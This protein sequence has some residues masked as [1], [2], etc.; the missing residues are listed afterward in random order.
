[1][2]EDDASPA[3]RLDGPRPEPT[4]APAPHDAESARDRAY[5]A[6][7]ERAHEVADE[8]LFAAPPAAPRQPLAPA[9]PY[10]LAS[11]AE[12]EPPRAGGRARA[13]SLLS[14]LVWVTTA[15]AL[16]VAVAPAALRELGLLES[17]R[18]RAAH[19]RLPSAARA[20]PRGLAHEV[21]DDEL[22][23]G[24]P[25]LRAPRG[26][27]DDDE[28]P[29]VAPGKSGVTGRGRAT[30][31][32]P[33]RAGPTESAEA[34]GRLEVGMPLSILKDQGGFSLVL[35]TDDEGVSMGWAPSS[36]I[37]RTPSAR[38]SPPPAPTRERP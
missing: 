2:S 32:A 5:E 20:A 8:L 36:A 13:L 22:P 7:R 28:A 37:E 12:G 29:L 17:P 18:A 23:P 1:M 11:G 9:A 38:P 33:L 21:D 19:L 35:A 16:G 24:H 34:I 15:G 3:T 4:G 27:D 14:V 6:G 26:D 10:V 31:A 30:R 25:R